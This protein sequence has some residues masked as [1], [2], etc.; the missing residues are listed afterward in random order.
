MMHEISRVLSNMDVPIWIAGLAGLV[1]AMS[2]VVTFRS[3][4]G[5][6]DQVTERLRPDRALR[7]Q[8]PNF[9]TYRVTEVRD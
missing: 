8:Q 2:V 6:P 9:W 1:C 4:V 5:T 7:G 3:L